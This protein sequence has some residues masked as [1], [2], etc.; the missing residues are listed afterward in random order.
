[1]SAREGG[2]VTSL[3][4]SG[5]LPV[6]SVGRWCRPECPQACKGRQATSGPIAGRLTKVRQGRVGLGAKNGGGHD[7]VGG[8]Q[9]KCGKIGKI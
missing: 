8:N 5:D 7:P 9:K 6:L 4:L 1:M 3:L 2:G